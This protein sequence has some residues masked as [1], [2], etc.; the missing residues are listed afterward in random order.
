[1]K[2]CSTPLI[3]REIQIKTQRNLTSHLLGWMSSKRQE[4]TNAGDAMKKQKLY[5]LLR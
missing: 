5:K 2:K 1:M 4:M 3:N